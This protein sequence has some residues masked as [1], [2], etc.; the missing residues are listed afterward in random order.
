MK[1]LNFVIN[2]SFFYFKIYFFLI[3]LFILLCVRLVFYNK[4]PDTLKN[5]SA[6]VLVTNPSYIDDGVIVI[7]ST[8]YVVRTRQLGDYKMGYLY[9]IVG[10][11]YYNTIYAKKITIA[12]KSYLEPLFYLKNI[13]VTSISSVLLEPFASLILGMLYGVPP[14]YGELQKNT[15]I[16][17]GVIHVIVVSGYNISILFSFVSSIFSLVSIKKRMLI[18]SLISV[19]FAIFTGFESPIL[20]ALVFGLII[21]F[22]K[23]TG[24]KASIFYVLLTTGILIGIL[25]PRILFSVSFQ[26]S[27]MACV[28]LVLLSGDFN[29]LLNKVY[30]FNILPKELKESFVSSFCAQLMVFPILLYYFNDFSL[31]SLV[32]NVLVLWLVPTIMLLG[33]FLSILSLFGLLYFTKIFL[34]VVYPPLIFFVDVV[35]LMSNIPFTLNVKLSTYTV[36]FIYFCLF[37]LIFLYTKVIKNRLILYNDKEVT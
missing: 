23:A 35:E 5:F 37:L 4:T 13:L 15:L 16:K 29:F 9:N 1:Y 20:R 12:E 25:S 17:A 28:G 36:V 7:N 24:N 14:N 34:I 26:L 27:F 32:T 21:A 8:P 19:T 33:I 31:I 11:K 18:A 2:R 10:D 30:I 3:L 6:K 22:A